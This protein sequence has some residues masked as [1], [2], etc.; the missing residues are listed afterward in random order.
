M[1]LMNIAKGT[2][3]RG[4]ELNQF[5]AQCAHECDGFNTMEEYAS[6]AAYEGRSDLGNTQP[7]DGKR[8]KGRGYIQ[9]TG[10]ANYRNIGRAIGVDLENNPLKA[11]E[12]AVAAKVAL[13][14]WNTR[15]KTRIATYCDT[16]G[17]TRVINGG[18]NG[19]SDRERKF[20]QYGGCSGRRRRQLVTEANPQIGRWS[21]DS[22][23]I[24]ESVRKKILDKMN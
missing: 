18:T 17:V 13:N 1:A 2:G 12:P 15:V 20:S 16:T 4:A 22:V 6:G 3:M 11:L 24:A 14:Y 5:M 8:Y 9:I 10:R 23:G 7:G 19:L 21:Y